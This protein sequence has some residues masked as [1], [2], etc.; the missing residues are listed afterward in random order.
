[1]TF[2]VF[3]AVAHVFSN[4]GLRAPLRSTQLVKYYQAARRAG[5]DE[6]E[7]VARV[8]AWLAPPGND[9]DD[10]ESVGFSGASEIRIWFE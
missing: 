4:A 7:S 3:R 10:D 1:M 9:D 6:E 8:T 2:C 5:D